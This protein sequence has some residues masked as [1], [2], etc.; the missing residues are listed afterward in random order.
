[1]GDGFPKILNLK[2][3]ELK[4]QYHMAFDLLSWQDAA[5]PKFQGSAAGC[6]SI[7]EITQP[8]QPR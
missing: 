2:D 6:S 1:V 8:C 3:V 4:V 7:A 5:L